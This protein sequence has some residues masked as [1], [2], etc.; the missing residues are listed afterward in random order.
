MNRRYGD[1]GGSAP[2]GYLAKRRRRRAVTGTAANSSAHPSAKANCHITRARA[3]FE[4]TPPNSPGWCPTSEEGG[5][6]SGELGLG[7]LAHPDPGFLRANRVLSWRA[8]RSALDCSKLKAGRHL[9]FERT[10]PRRLVRQVMISGQQ[11]A[12]KS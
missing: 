11:A 2:R 10:I 12:I 1:T 9:K 4:W 6:G 5:D 7:D 3:R 8:W